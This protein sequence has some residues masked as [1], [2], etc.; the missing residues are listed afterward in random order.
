[1]NAKKK[2]PSAAA[3]KKRAPAPA[4][5]GR[6]LTSAARTRPLAPADLDAVVAIDATLMGRTR[7]AYFERRLNAALRQPKLHLQFA[8]ESEGT[9]VGY[10][11]GRVLEGEFGRTQP[12]LR[13][14]VISVAR[15]AQGRGIGWVLHAALE[16]AA[17]KRGLAEL[18]TAA[19]WRDSAMLSFLA[20]TGYA[21]SGALVLDCALH[22]NPLLTRPESVSSPSRDKPGDPNDWSAPQANDYEQLSR[23]TADLR[24]LTAKD[25][26]DV[27]RI[28]RHITGRERRAYVQ[29]ALD[30][31]LRET[32]V[33]IS[34]A[35]RKD[36]VMAGY[37]MARADLGD[38]GRTEPVAVIDTLGVAPEYEHHGVGHALLQQLFLN[39][40]A[41]RIERVE[42]LVEARAQA[43]L[44][45]FHGAGF[46]P[47]QRLAFV[48]A[49]A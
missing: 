13:L 32:G 12:G 11:L 20:A 21:L 19:P 9:L 14:E 35:A 47:S 8:A 28:D 43:L 16:Q 40:A 7:R 17:R 18:R 29:H 3:A 30:E 4:P 38:F 27:V 36:G 15:G 49:L 22:E 44:G 37:V 26:D 25:L 24:L 48:K 5:R 33:R 23:D 31:A 2:R 6:L 39:L 42:T 45:F 34:L 1:M 10:A 46:A 41:L